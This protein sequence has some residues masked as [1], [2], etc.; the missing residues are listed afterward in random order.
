MATNNFDFIPLKRYSYVNLATNNLG[1]YMLK[2]CFR[3]NKEKSITNFKID[4]R[5]KDGRTITCREC[6][7]NNKLDKFFRTPAQIES[8]RKKLLGRKY[9]VSHRLAISKGQQLAVKEGRHPWKRN[10]IEHKEQERHRL[11]YQLWKQKVIELK[12]NLCETC[13]SDK[14]IHV[15]HIKCFYKYPELRTDINNGQVLC[16]SCHMKVTWIERKNKEVSNAVQ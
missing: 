12:G 13:K 10:E 2:M 9:S 6:Y 8:Q 5:Q 1:I 7:T 4:N 14:R 3:C 11:S 16:Q 15:H